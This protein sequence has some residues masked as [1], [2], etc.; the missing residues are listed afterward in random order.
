MGCGG[1]VFFEKQGAKTH[2]LRV[3]LAIIAQS[4]H[5]SPFDMHLVA[6]SMPINPANLGGRF[7]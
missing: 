3:A 6:K 4:S 1:V 2:N 7:R 5:F